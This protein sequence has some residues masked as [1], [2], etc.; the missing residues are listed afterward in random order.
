MVIGILVEEDPCPPAEAYVSYDN[1][2]NAASGRQPLPAWTACVLL[3]G[4]RHALWSVGVCL[5]VPALGVQTRS[6]PASPREIIF[7]PA[8]ASDSARLATPAAHRRLQSL[9]YHFGDFGEGTL[10]AMPGLRD[11]VEC[12]YWTFSGQSQPIMA[13]RGSRPGDGLADVL[14]GALFAVILQCLEHACRRE[15]LCHHSM[16][17]AL[18]LEPQPLQIAWADDLSLLVDFPSS[19][20]A[21]RLLPRLATLILQTIEAFRFRGGQDRGYC[22]ALWN[23][24]NTSPTAA[25]SWHCWHPI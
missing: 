23:R 2:T 20:E 15:G 19:S 9:W 16:C 17:E 12:S 4:V 7:T 24:G 3:A 11:C 10:W 6:A 5:L 18:G 22:Q 1:P 13:S 14:F 25:S 8:A 21:M